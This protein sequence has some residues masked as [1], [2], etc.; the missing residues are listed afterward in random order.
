MLEHY[1]FSPLV[2]KAWSSLSSSKFLG[3]INDKLSLCPTDP[4]DSQ[5]C[6]YVNDYEIVTSMVQLVVSLTV[7]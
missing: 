5:F 3:P 6:L 7:G 1:R 2:S 4:K